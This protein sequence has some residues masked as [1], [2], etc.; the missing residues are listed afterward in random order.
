M[1]AQR[2]RARR[3][4]GGR[5]CKVSISA[6]G[7]RPR[8][9]IAR[10]GAVPVS[11]SSSSSSSDND[12]DSC[13]DTSTTQSPALR[14]SPHHRRR[15]RRGT[16]GPRGHRAAAGFVSGDVVTTSPGWSG[17]GGSFHRE[18]DFQ[19]GEGH[20]PTHTGTATIAA[21]HLQSHRRVPY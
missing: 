1:S 11:L 8:G 3:R 9:S 20:I 12:S 17:H 4:S 6:L 14:R 19:H 2:R 15:Q 7:G 5:G 16:C 13:S 18:Q 10:A 21:A